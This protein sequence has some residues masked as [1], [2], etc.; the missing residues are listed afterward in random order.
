MAQEKDYSLKVRLTQLTGAFVKDLTGRTATKKCIIIPVDD[1]PCMFVGERR[2]SQH[3]RLRH[4]QPAVRRHPHAET[5]PAQ[6]GA[7]ADDRRAA[8][9]A[10]H[11]RQHAP[12][13]T[14]GA[15]PG[16]AA[17]RGSIGPAERRPSILIDN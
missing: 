3:H 11:S 1:N 10:A 4:R 12:P 6:G 7:R 16:P 13:A 9:P 5:Q 17:L 2:V 15:E 8:P 14:G